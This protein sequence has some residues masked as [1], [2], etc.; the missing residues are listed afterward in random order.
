MSHKKEGLFVYFKT[1][2]KH[3]IYAFNKIKKG[4]KL[5]YGLG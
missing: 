4:D 3:F 5:C 2:F 1:F